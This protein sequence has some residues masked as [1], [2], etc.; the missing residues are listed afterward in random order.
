MINIYADISTPGGLLMKS[1]DTAEEFMLSGYL[2]RGAVIPMRI[3]PVEPIAGA[4]SA[5]FYAT[6]S[7]GGKTLSVA[8][9]S[10]SGASSVLALTADDGWLAVNGADGKGYFQG[11]LSLATAEIETAFAANPASVSSYLEIRFTDEFGPRVICQRA[12]D[13]YN[14]VVRPTSSAPVGGD[15]YQTNASARAQFVGWDNSQDPN[16]WGRGIIIVSPDGTKKGMLRLE[17]DGSFTQ[18]LIS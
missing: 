5:P 11:N 8:V 10:R 14:S 9:G 12:V 15:T 6:L 17:N 13:V 3:W 7:T 1:V 4:A 18:S 2:T 16:N